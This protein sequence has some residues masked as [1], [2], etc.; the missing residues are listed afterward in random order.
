MSYLSI[1]YFQ[2]VPSGCPC[3]PTTG[4][5]AVNACPADRMSTGGCNSVRLSTGQ[6]VFNL[7]LLSISSVGGIGWGFSL[8]YLSGSQI[9]DVLGNHFNFPQQL[10]LE[11]TDGGAGIN[12]VDVVTGETT[13]EMFEETSGNSNIYVPSPGNN[14]RAHLAVNNVGSSSEEFVLTPAAGVET[15]FGG[16]DSGIAAGL[17]GKLK[18]IQDRFGN[19]QTYQ[20]SE[21]DTD[22]Y[23]LASVTDSYGRTVSYSYDGG[24]PYRLLEIKDFLE[25]KLTFT[26]DANDRLESVVTPS[27]TTAAEG[28]TFPG[29]TAY[30]F[31]YKSTTDLIEKIWYPNQCAPYVNDDRTVDISGVK[32]N[33]TP[34]Y[35][36]EYDGSDRVIK[37]TVGDDP[38]TPTVGGSYTFSYDDSPST[39]NLIDG[40][41][42]IVD[43]TT[44]TDRNGNETVYSFTQAGMVARLRVKRNRD[45]IDI[46]ST[47]T[48]PQYDTWTAY[49]ENNQPVEVVFPE[50]NSVVY[51]YEDGTVSGISGTYNP[52]VGLLLRETRKPGNTISIPSRSGS[53]GQTELTRRFFYDPIFNQQTAVIEER[54]NPIASG[55]TYFT[56]QNGGTTPSNSD[57]SRYATITFFDYQQNTKTSVQNDSDL[58]ALLGLNSTEIGDLIDHVDDQMKATD[59][60][61]GLRTVSRW[62]WGTLTVMARATA[63]VQDCRPRAF[64]AAWSKSNT[65]TCG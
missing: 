52:R 31:A 41:D 21:I 56:P 14:S 35:T 40:S 8:N 23:R 49:N 24:S 53:S 63:T 30:V 4:G 10:H 48:F 34:R 2:S 11:F 19:E 32:N 33:A 5:Q 22:V 18:S 39:T 64:W 25:R 54:G 47:G 9:D 51:E 13:V 6:F 45:K 50:G 3:S 27:V 20:W 62:T 55:P 38:I 61:G 44:V 16:F 57:R 42:P 65:P 26:Y 17:R 15:T 46:P 12:M 59:G 1:D 43:E 28:N 60:S 37:E 29:G 7:P 58:Q 36:V